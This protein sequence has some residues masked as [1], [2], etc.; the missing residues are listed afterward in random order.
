MRVFTD[1]MKREAYEGKKRI[2]P[3]CK[4][5]NK[6]KWVNEGMEVNLITPWHEGGKTT[7]ENCHTL[8][9]QHNHTEGGR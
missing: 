1:K 2:C 8:C 7:A 5:E 6:K 9:K 4:G 3:F